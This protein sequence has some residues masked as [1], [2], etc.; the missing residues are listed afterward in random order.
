MS[1]IGKMPVVLP[2]EVECV[3][4]GQLVSLSGKLGKLSFSFPKEVSVAFAF[5]ITVVTAIVVAATD[6]KTAAAAR[7]CLCLRRRHHRRRHCRCRHSGYDRRVMSKSPWLFI[8][9]E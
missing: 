6:I 1:R 5:A 7:L 2:S 4:E 8:V 9:D 3:I